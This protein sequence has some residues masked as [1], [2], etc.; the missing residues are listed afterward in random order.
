MG[1]LRGG[2]S[3]ETMF[4]YC[5]STDSFPNR[6]IVDTSTEGKIGHD[7]PLSHDL[8]PRYDTYGMYVAEFIKTIV[9]SSLKWACKIYPTVLS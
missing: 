7:C 5:S 9:F 6:H 4:F 3:S 1:C 8:D 2:K